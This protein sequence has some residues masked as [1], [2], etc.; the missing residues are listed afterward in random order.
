MENPSFYPFSFNY[1]I[2]EAAKNGNKNTVQRTLFAFLSFIKN[3]NKNIIG[4]KFSLGHKIVSVVL[5]KHF[6]KV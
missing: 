2:I 5:K 3:H 4:Y 6:G 1:V